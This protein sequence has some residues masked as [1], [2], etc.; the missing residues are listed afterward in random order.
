MTDTLLVELL[1]EELPPKALP[2]L[3]EAFSHGLYEGLKDKGLLRPGADVQPYA[4][5]RR[6]A[7]TISQVLDKQPDRLVVLLRRHP[8]RIG[9]AVPHQTLHQSHP[10]VR[11]AAR[12]THR[13][14]PGPEEVGSSRRRPA[15]LPPR[16]R[17]TPDKALGDA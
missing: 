5:P 15:A 7:V 16:H 10:M 13:P 3:M 17:M 8:H 12:R 4:S 9:P 11:D 2:R 14:R 6:L 1:T